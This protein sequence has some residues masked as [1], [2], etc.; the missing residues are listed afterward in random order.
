VPDSSRMFDCIG[1]CP[2]LGLRDAF[3]ITRLPRVAIFS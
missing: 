2:F 3:V 1:L